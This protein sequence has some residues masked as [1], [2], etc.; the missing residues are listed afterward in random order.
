[1]FSLCA[2]A[3]VMTT[4][5]VK[6]ALQVGLPART[7][8]CAPPGAQGHKGQG[9]RADKCKYPTLGLFRRADL[10]VTPLFDNT[11]YVRGIP[12]T[13]SSPRVALRAARVSGVLYGPQS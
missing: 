10:I 4:G 1:M 11:A 13:R 7:S 12:S 5:T 2:A 3:C 6:E 9:G 8:V